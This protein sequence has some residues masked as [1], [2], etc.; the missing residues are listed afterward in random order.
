MFC[1]TNSEPGCLNEKYD[2]LDF[3]GG[4]LSTNHIC[5]GIVDCALNTDEKGCSRGNITYHKN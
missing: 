3:G 4:C 5:D 2:C 1:L